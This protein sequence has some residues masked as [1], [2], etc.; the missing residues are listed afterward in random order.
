[1]F[2]GSGVT[3]DAEFSSVD[4]PSKL[5]EALLASS[6]WLLKGVARHRSRKH[7]F[8]PEHNAFIEL[9]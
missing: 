5:V 1:V 2:S 6:A 9:E 3:K 4:E 7:K 8:S